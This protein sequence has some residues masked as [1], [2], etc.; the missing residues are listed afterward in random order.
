MPP[1]RLSAAELD[2]FLRGQSLPAR[3]VL[4]ALRRIVLET[5]PR[6]VESVRFGA[7]CYYYSGKP[8]G[9]IGGNI[10]MIEVR[11]GRVVLSF[12]Q[13]A[14]LHDPNAL[15]RGKGK[16]KR[17]VPIETVAAARDPRIIVLIREA[18]R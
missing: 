3:R 4:R 10:C 6:A 17:F 13:G 5:V 14:S 15:L 9:A 2:I 11:R 1:L 18:A 16:A 7:L 8:Y 12:I